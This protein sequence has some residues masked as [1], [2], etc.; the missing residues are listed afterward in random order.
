[1]P[2]VERFP[3]NETQAAKRLEFANHQI[4]VGTNWDSVIFVDE[5]MFIKDSNSRWVWRKRSDDNPLIY[6]ESSKFPTKVMVF[7][8]ISK[9][10]RT[11]LISIEGTVDANTYV[12][13]CIDGTGLIPA[14]NEAYGARQWS[15]C[16]DGATPHTARATKE[17]LTLFCNIIEDWPPGSPDLN[18]IEN[19]WSILKRHVEQVQPQ[20]KEDLINIIFLF[21]SSIQQVTIDN[22]I[23]SMQNRLHSVVQANGYHTYYRIKNQINFTNR[24]KTML[25]LYMNKPLNSIQFSCKVVA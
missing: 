18:P 1:L 9:L 3:L 22:L 11:P 14:M 5:S 21:W 25:P 15:L 23:N 24:Q 10:W 17:Y 7:G 8:G 6:N 4:S 16:Q 19:L 13:E 12:D 2:P 20:T